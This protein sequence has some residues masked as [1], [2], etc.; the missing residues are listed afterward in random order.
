[1][2]QNIKK[3]RTKKKK[4]SKSKKYKY[5]NK[6]K[7]KLASFEIKKHQNYNTSYEAEYQRAGKIVQ[8]EI[9]IIEV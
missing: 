1:M 7:T 4:K 9:D 3:R 5:K 6:N 2:N 8:L